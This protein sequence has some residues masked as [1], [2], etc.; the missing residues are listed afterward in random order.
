MDL[1]RFDLIET[2]RFTPE[3]GIP[4]LELHLER[5]RESTQA[6]GFAY[7]R[8]ALRNAI[9]ALCFD[10]ERPSKLR[11]VAARSGAFSLE[12]MDL[13]PDLPKPALCGVL[14]LPVASS[15]RRLRHK[16][17]DRD[18]YARGLAVAQ[19]AGADEALFLRDDGLVTEG[20]FTNVFVARGGMLLTPPAALGLLPGVLRRSLIEAGGAREAELTLDDLADGFLIG[21]ALRG[22]IPAVLLT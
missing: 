17:T 11:L 10:A 13:P 4:L 9:Q 3:D 6:L 18:F 19:A 7:D 14:P 2:M 8:H 15:D 12:L 5:L 16:T 22:L 20:C 21:N 1:P